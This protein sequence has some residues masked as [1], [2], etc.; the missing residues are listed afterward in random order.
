MRWV[1]KWW[2]NYLMSHCC[3]KV[4]D[5]SNLRKVDLGS[6][7][8]E[9]QSIPTRHGGRNR[10]LASQTV[11][12]GNRV[13]KGQ[14]QANKPEGP[15]PVTLSHQLLKVAYIT[16]PH[17]QCCTSPEQGQV[18]VMGAG[19][20]P[21][22]CRCASTAKSRRFRLQS[23]RWKALK[24]DM[25]PQLLTFRVHTLTCVSTH[26]Y[27]CPPAH[28]CASYMQSILLTSYPL[29]L[30]IPSCITNN[31]T[32]IRLKKLHTDILSDIHFIVSFHQIP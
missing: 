24:E 5:T 11:Q 18:D 12:S 32:I 3:D 26:T 10:R 22:A 21:R 13:A 23:V 30:N 14:S 29:S 4:S 1:V 16:V 25:W 27:T 28:T 20:C 15:S 19:M 8:E 31:T 9:I 17:F 7:I 2:A 6:Q